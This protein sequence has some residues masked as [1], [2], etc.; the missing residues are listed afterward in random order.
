[1]MCQ[2]SPAPLGGEVFKN[3][4]FFSAFFSKI[5]IKER[6]SPSGVKAFLL[7]AKIPLSN[8]LFL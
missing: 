2:D 4:I 6:I 8:R 3:Q 7:L 1:M 5:F